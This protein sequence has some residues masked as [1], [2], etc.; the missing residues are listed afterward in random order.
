MFSARGTFPLQ[1]R[2]QWSFPPAASLLLGVFALTILLM[3]VSYRA[4]TSQAHLHSIFQPM[5]DGLL[6]NHHH[7]PTTDVP[8]APS[9]FSSPGVPLSASAPSSLVEAET[10]VPRQLEMAGAGLAITAILA[11]R[12]L[13]AVLL[14]GSAVRPLWTAPFH[15]LSVATGPE[16]PP[17]RA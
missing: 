5:L 16:P 10:D 17:P 6:G 1:L 14:A 15:G 8:G 7:H 13:I 12:G 9:P 3:P 2:L 4:G 11:L